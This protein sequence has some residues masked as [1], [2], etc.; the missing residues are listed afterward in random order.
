MLALLKD[1]KNY[2]VLR[3]DYA[4]RYFKDKWQLVGKAP[5]AEQALEN[6]FKWIEASFKATGDGGSA[7]YYRMGKGW[8]ASYPETT[9]YLIPTLYEYGLYTGNTKWSHIAKKAG[10]W[11]V[12]IQLPEGGWQGL[13]VDVKADPRVFNTGMILD[14]LVACYTI[15]KDK[16]YL[17]SAVKGM[18]WL[19]RV[20]DKNG[21]FSEYNVS[22]GGSFDTLVCAGM[23]MVT[24]HLKEPERSA[25]HAKIKIS[26]DA[27]ASLQLE[28]KLFDRCSFSHN[29]QSL[30]HHIGYTLDGLIICSDL[31]ENDTYFN[32]ALA[33]ARKLLSV[34]E[35]NLELPAYCYNDWKPVKDLNGKR[36][37]LCLTGYSQTA[38]VFQ[39]IA[40]KTKDLRYLNA[41]LKINDI[42]SAIG[43]QP[44]RNDG[45]N[46]GLAG[47]YPV[48]GIYQP[49][50]MVNWAAKYHAESLLLSLNKNLAKKAGK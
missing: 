45:I 6:V 37:S 20:Q 25:Y 48:S 18:D 15:E 49:F 13:Q 9:G 5:H 46:F 39:K 11:L 32:V 30:L 28:N 4:S 38:I 8:K 2:K 43:N 36:S 1:I 21:F 22:G 44:S 41:A 14:G 26:V 47:S 19:L 31:L 12:S 27:L 29:G 40:A 34:F 50:Q 42:V 35:V 33:T 10:D 23:L 3:P 16:K 24:Q 7:A 17:D